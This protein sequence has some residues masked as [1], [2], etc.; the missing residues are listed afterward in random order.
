MHTHWITI[1][2]VHIVIFRFVIFHMIHLHHPFKYEFGTLYAKRNEK[3][4]FFI[5]KS[6]GKMTEFMIELKRS[7]LAFFYF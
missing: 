2:F 7:D 6:T 1:T 5:K 3:F 4:R